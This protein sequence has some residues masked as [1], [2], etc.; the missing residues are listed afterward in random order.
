M[1]NPTNDNLPAASSLSA[2]LKGKKIVLVNHSDTLGCAAKA[3]F[4][5][6]QAL[7]RE[8]LDVRMV[9]YTRSSS[10]TNVSEVGTPLS[11]SIRYC[12]ERLF[13]MAHCDRSSHGN[14]V[15]ST[16]T[17]AVN[18]HNHPWVREA[19]IVCLNWINLG[20][21]NLRGIR[22]LHEAGKKIVWTLH[23]M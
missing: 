16:G 1:S 19:D 3:T 18:I 14:Y 20:L 12:A 13:V 11:R 21:M 2:S 10:E 9:V 8:G 17:L 6:M 4:R 22:R 15:V 5:L 23:D 7:R